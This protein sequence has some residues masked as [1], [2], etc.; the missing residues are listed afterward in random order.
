MGQVLF[1]YFIQMSSFMWKGD[2]YPRCTDEEIKSHLTAY[3]W[4]DRHLKPGSHF[5]HAEN[6]IKGDTN[7]NCHRIPHDEVFI[8][9]VAFEA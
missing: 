4:W 2:C 1:K 6:L 7:P 9:S 8:S 5:Q 3:K